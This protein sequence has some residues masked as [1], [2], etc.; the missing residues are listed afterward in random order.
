MQGKKRNVTNQSCLDFYSGS[1]ALPP[2]HFSVESE[3]IFCLAYVKLA[4]RSCPYRIILEGATVCVTCSVLPLHPRS[5]PL[6]ASVLLAS[7]LMVAHRWLRSGR[8][9]PRFLLLLDSGS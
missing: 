6:L 4:F 1:D 7:C 3:H 5:C 9:Y 2:E 8:P